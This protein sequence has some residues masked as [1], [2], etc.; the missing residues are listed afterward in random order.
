MRY[1]PKFT[2]PH[3]EKEIEATVFDQGGPGVG[4]GYLGL[5]DCEASRK[6][7]DD[8]SRLAYEARKRKRRKK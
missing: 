5:C 8:S 3:C 6:A 4:A 7:A 1:V 2:C